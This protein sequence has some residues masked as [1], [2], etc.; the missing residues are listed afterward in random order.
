MAKLA[1]MAK[2][3]SPN[4]SGLIRSFLFLSAALGGIG[5]ALTLLHRLLPFLQILV[6]VLGVWWVWQRHRK[7]QQRQQKQLNT[8]FYRLLQE[9]SGRMTLLDFAMTA[10]IPAV[11]ARHYLDSRAKEFAAR[12][13]VTEQGDVVYVFSTLQF[14]RLKPTL[15]A[16]T[17]TQDDSADVLP[18]LDAL[19]QTELAKRLG[20]AAKTISRKKHLP[21]LL[22]WS[23]TRDPNGVSWSYD[24]EAQRFLPLS[25]RRSTQFRH[26][27]LPAQAEE[28]GAAAPD[29]GKRL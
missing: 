5:L 12:F 10:A 15:T 25:D 3:T 19:T 24:A 20:V 22:A 7:T 18:L 17:V 8:L 2:T 27:Q 1:R 4:V 11:V 21:T 28:E 6:P 26:K 16:T 29:A 13:E 14:S 23:Q 9:H